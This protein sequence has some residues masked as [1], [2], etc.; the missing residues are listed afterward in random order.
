MAL[1][2]KTT[3]EDRYIHS[4]VQNL[5]DVPGGVTV[6]T[7][8]LIPGKPLLEGA[9]V[10]RKNSAGICTI[11]KTA[12][13]HTTAG[14]DATSYQVEKGSH[15]KVGDIITTGA[16]KTAA[17]I[18]SVDR[19]SSAL[20]DTIT[21]A[22]T[23]GAATKGDTLVQANAANAKAVLPTPYGRLVDNHE[24]KAEDNLFAPVCVIGTYEGTLVPQSAD[25]DAKLPGIVLL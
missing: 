19:D 24:V 11:I 15:F 13:V 23:I 21:V 22:T 18:A 5:A 3:G 17:A 20:F 7:A 16:G 10:S 9:Y 12:T 1:R 14:S 25:L 4:I 6:S 2:I 8:A